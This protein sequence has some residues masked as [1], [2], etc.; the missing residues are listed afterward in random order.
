WFFCSAAPRPPRLSPLSLQ[1]RSSDLDGIGDFRGLTEKLDYI[2]DLGVNTVWVMPFY[3]S[4]LRDDG[5]DVAD[6]ESVHPP[7]G[8]VA[9][10]KRS[11]EHTSEL[12]SLAYLVCR[13]LPEK[14]K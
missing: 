13:L 7:Y 14:K 5:Y 12:Q 1:R 2:R 9:D 6:F 8:T 4:P 11:E 3:P 10:F